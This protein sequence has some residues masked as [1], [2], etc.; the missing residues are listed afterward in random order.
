MNI[1]ITRFQITL[2]LKKKKICFSSALGLHESEIRQSENV[3][4]QKK[5]NGK[6]MLLLKIY[7]SI[8][9]LQILFSIA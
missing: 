7:K 2:C 9:N 6:K 4:T 1:T 5:G 8:F 3:F